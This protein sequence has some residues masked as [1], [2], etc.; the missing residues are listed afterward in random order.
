[1]NRTHEYACFKITDEKKFQEFMSEHLN[2]M[3]V[4]K[5]G[6]SVVILGC[7]KEPFEREDYEEY[8]FNA[9]LIDEMHPDFLD[10][11]E[12]VSAGKP[13]KPLETLP[14]R[15]ITQGWRFFECEDC[16][17]SWKSACRD[18]LSPSGENCSKCG[19]PTAPYTGQEDLTL[20]IDEFGNL[21]SDQCT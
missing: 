10:F 20:P 15:K 3:G 2:P 14:P 17:H 5:N 4:E 12:W 18:H 6:Y 21:R 8:L 19:T 7:G 16:Y 9:K 1:M 13:K 11:D